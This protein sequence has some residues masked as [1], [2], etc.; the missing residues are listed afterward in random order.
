MYLT[1]VDKVIIVELQA[2]PWGPKAIADTSLNEQ[3]KSMSLEQFRKNVD[4]VKRIRF[5]EAYLWGAE[6]WYWLKTEKGDDRIWE[7]ARGVFNEEY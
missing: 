4:Y 5:S 3:Y 2:E 6:W 7:E 1:G